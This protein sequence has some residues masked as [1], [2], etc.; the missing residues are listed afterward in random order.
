MAALYNAVD[1]HT[2]LDFDAF[3][4]DRDAVVQRAREAGVT[5]FVIAGAD[6]ADWERVRRVADALEATC[7]LGIHPWWVAGRAPAQLDADLQR[8]DSFTELDGI[9]ETGLD[10]FRAKSDDERA[11]QRAVFAAHIDLA[12]TRNLPLVLHVVRAHADALGMLAALDVPANGGLVHAWSAGPE[13]VEPALE[14]GLHLSF[15]TDLARSEAAREALK[16]VPIERLLLETDCPDRPL[17]GF[18]RGEPAHL[19]EIARIAAEIRDTSPDDLLARCGDN[20][21]ALFGWM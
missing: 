11:A 1:A 3:E 7:C 21:R 10:W 16:E 17:A 9:G 13:W 20:A 14:L 18:E 12:H 2:H 5:D 8:L 19:V 15:G 6:P 4:S